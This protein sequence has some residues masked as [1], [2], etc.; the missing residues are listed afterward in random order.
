MS[1]AAKTWLFSLLVLIC[2]YTMF[3][4][5]SAFLVARLLLRARI[6][7][8]KCSLKLFQTFFVGGSLFILVSDCLGY[9]GRFGEITYCMLVYF[10]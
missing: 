4:K 5:L 1:L 6:S 3:A 2:S 9:V 10:C 8:V 7:L